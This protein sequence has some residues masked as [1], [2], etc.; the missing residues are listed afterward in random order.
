M[1]KK[2]ILETLKEIKDI[3]NSKFQKI[4]DID[5]ISK[6][7]AKLDVQKKYREKIVLDLL[8]PIVKELVDGLNIIPK[9]LLKKVDGSFY[10]D[11]IIYYIYN[12]CGDS[13]EVRCSVKYINDYLLSKKL[14]RLDFF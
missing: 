4:L 8:N 3:S 7:V 12:I 10:Q 14:Y 5:V 11:Q 2:S 9:R 13:I 6:E 1:K